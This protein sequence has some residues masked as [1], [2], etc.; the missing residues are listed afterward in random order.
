MKVIINFKKDKGKE[1]PQK[2][3]ENY[4][5]NLMKL[6]KNSEVNKDSPVINNSINEKNKN[7]SVSKRKFVFM[8]EKKG[9]I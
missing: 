4:S 9:K 5:Q 7:L 8:I 6:I 2:K 3:I 1:S